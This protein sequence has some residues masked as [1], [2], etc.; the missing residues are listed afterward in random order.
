M[1]VL[2]IAGAI[3][4]LAA[5]ATA[6][7]H[8]AKADVLS[9]TVPYGDLD[10]SRTAGAD[11]M[12]NRIAQAARYVCGEAPRPG[13]LAKRKRHRACLATATDSA[14]AKLDAPVVTARHQGRNPAMLAAR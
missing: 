10:L 6:G 14:V 4:A 1:R 2:T 3:L 8:S 11:L 9:T 12:L 7:V 5:P 13:D